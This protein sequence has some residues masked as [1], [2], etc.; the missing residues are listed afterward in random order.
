MKSQASLV[1]SQC[2]VELNTITPVDL[3]LAL[4]ILP[5]DAELYDSFGNRGDLQSCLVFRVFFEERGIFKCRDKL[6]SEEKFSKKNLEEV[7]CR[8]GAYLYK[9]AQIQAQMEGLT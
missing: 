8:S 6:Y 4:V 3:N 5:N 7:G 9:L 1:G 2:G